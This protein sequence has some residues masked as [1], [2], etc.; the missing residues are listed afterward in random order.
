M[1]RE[2][3]VEPDPKGDVVVNR[4]R[5]WGRL[6]KDHAN[7]RP[8]KIEV[9]PRGEN[10]MSVDE[11]FSCSALPG[12][13][14]VN[15]IEHSKKGRLSATRWADECSHTL[16]MQRQC[17]VLQSFEAAVIKIEVPDQNLLAGSRLRF[18]LRQPWL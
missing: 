12:I 18:R 8:Q 3:L 17:H 9:Q 10:I 13:K 5:K 1:A 11:N 15:S 14:F 2:P 7:P 4:H 16:I 6:L